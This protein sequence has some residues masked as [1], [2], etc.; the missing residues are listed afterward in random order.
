MMGI[1]QSFFSI[2]MVIGPLVGGLL[3]AIEPVYV[4]NLS[5]IMFLLGFL[6]LLFLE[7]KVKRELRDIQANS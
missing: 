1:R 2:G 7:K 3:Y 4:F 5:A 6:L